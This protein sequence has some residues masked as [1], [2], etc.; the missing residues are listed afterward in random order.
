MNILD[1]DAFDNSS[2]SAEPW[3]WGILENLLPLDAVKK[4]SNELNL[5][6]FDTVISR[7]KEKNYQM[8]LIDL[9]K[10][11]VNCDVLN[12]VI[13][14]LRSDEY[15]SRFEIFTDCQL[16]GR[17]IELNIWRYSESNYLSPHVDK[18][19]KFLTQLLY[20]NEIWHAD[21]GGS[22]NILGSSDE[23]VIY[24]R[25]LRAYQVS[26]VIKNS[27]NAWHSVSPVTDHAPARYCLQM[28]YKEGI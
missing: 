11:K 19:Y 26:P 17:D 24:Q 7:R 12:A 8:E 6:E 27:Q 9:Q 15:L 23:Q 14:D 18:R 2:F 22:L 20:L 13:E 4:I 5:L 1:L 16:R 25:I 21:Y 3:D 28:I 10:T